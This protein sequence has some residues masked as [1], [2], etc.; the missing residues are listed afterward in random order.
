M[1]HFFGMQFGRWE[2]EHCEILVYTNMWI[3][4]III[5]LQCLEKEKSQLHV[6]IKKLMEELNTQNGRNDLMSGE[7]F[8]LEMCLKQE[9]VM[10]VC[11]FIV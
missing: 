6:E 3:Y 9:K 5:Y 1:S 2:I 8:R 4:S 7:I 10:F 11:F